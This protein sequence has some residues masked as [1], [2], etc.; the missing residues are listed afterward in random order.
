MVLT[1]EIEHRICLSH[2]DVESAIMFQWYLQTIKSLGE[3]LEILYGSKNLSTLSSSTSHSLPKTSST[4][5]KTITT[6]PPEVLLKK[7]CDV[8]NPDVNLYAPE[9]LKCYLYVMHD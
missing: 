4:T 7:L 9:F 1:H 6:E 5:Q 2:I 3:A 8:L